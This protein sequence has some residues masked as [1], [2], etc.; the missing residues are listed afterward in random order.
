MYSVPPTA[1]LALVLTVW[2]VCHGSAAA[3]PPPVLKECE[4]LITSYHRKPAP[5]QALQ[6]FGR[7]LEK[8][9]IEQ[10]ALTTRGDT[11]PLLG[12]AFGSMARGNPKLVRGYE[13][14]FAGTTATGRRLLLECLRY[15]GDDQTLRQLDAWLKD[16]ALG[17]LREPLEA[18]R[19]FLA[20]PKRKLPRDRPAAAPTDLDLLWADFLV[21]GDYAPVAR[22]LDT[23]DLPDRV[24]ERLTAWLAKNKEGRKAMLEDLRRLG[25]T[26]EKAPEKLA[27]GDLQMQLLAN[28]RGDNREAAQRVNTALGMTKE[29]WFVSVG[30]KGPAMWSLVSNLRQHPRLAEVLRQ[31]V[32]SRPENS[33]RYVERLLEA[34]AELEKEGKKEKK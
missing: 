4:K 12:C 20:D 10:P 22:I 2:L 18:T 14:R 5:E 11:L 7:L 24:R 25:L 6:M 30:L 3:G 8:E 1:R 17:E 28:S 15:C 13:S 34:L 29:D 23:F 27:D 31:H 26:E 19:R 21:T 16:P 9:N 33:R 32:A